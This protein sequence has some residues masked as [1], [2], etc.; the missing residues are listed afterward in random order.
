M[1]NVI[2]FVK[3]NGMD[4]ESKENL[5]GL[6]RIIIRHNG[7]T[8][9]IR[10]RNSNRVFTVKGWEG[11]S[12]KYSVK[13][14]GV[15]YAFYANT[16]R[17]C[18]EYIKSQLETAAAE[19]AEENE[20]VVDESRDTETALLNLFTSEGNPTVTDNAYQV[21]FKNQL[22]KF[23]GLY[24]FNI[25]EFKALTAAHLAKEKEKADRLGSERLKG[26][27]AALE[28]ILATINAYEAAA[29]EKAAQAKIDAQKA[30]E[31]KE[32]SEVSKE[33][34]NQN[35]PKTHA[36]K[37]NK[38]K[39]LTIRR[40]ARTYGYDL[41]ELEGGVALMLEGYKFEFVTDDEYPSS[42]KFFCRD[43]KDKD[44]SV[45]WVLESNQLIALQNVSSWLSIH[46]DI[47]DSE[48]QKNISD[49]YIKNRRH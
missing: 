22:I 48:T 16:Q 49:F 32:A 31:A 28:I 11:H 37:A 19:E 26:R 23:G 43:F 40:F 10:E 33:A 17:E 4:F 45:F 29:A 12:E 38:G 6:R 13:I 39:F 44:G 14:D 46:T 15:M 25:D 47:K 34:S 36:K 18:V 20:V 27:V 8:I 41:E 21:G 9:V 30:T 7:Q 2:K 35:K 24:N 1:R 42:F 5:T 3:E